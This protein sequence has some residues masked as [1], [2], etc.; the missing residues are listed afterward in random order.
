MERFF[1][2]IYKLTR[3]IAKVNNDPRVLWFVLDFLNEELPKV[4]PHIANFTIEKRTEKEWIKIM[5]KY[6]IHPCKFTCKS[7]LLVLRLQLLQSSE[8]FDTT[9]RETLKLIFNGI[10]ES[11]PIITSIIWGH[12]NVLLDFF[13]INQA[14]SEYFAEFKSK[15]K[16]GYQNTVIARVVQ[17]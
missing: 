11:D 4:Q 16:H 10:H 7:H 12:V 5:Q 2:S 6:I 3:K 13:A 14:Q 9:K 17:S 8:W 1:K 15:E